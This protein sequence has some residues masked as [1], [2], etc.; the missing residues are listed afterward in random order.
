MCR[1]SPRAT[2][3]HASSASVR[4]GSAATCPPSSRTAC[5]RH[6]LLDGRDDG[7]GAGHDLRR[8]RRLVAV[9]DDGHEPRP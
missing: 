9:D 7:R 5:V 4:S 6:Q 8:G 2:K 1:P 3:S